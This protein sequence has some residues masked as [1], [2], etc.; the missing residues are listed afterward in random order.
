MFYAIN[1]SIHFRNITITEGWVDCIWIKNRFKSILLCFLKCCLLICKENILEAVS[2]IDP[3]LK[4]PVLSFLDIRPEKREADSAHPYLVVLEVWRARQV[5][6][7]WEGFDLA[8]FAWTGPRCRNM[9]ER[10]ESTWT[11][12]LCSLWKKIWKKNICQPH[13]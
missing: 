12:V 3:S 11:I 4:F 8:P 10:Y 9:I 2:E 6:H 13:V 7:L 1:N 5:W